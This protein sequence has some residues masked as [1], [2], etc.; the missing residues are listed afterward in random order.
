M[1]SIR[2]LLQIAVQ[3]DLLIHHMDVKS[4]SLDYEICVEPPEGF[5]G[6]NGNYVWKLKKSLYGLKQSGR[7]WNKT[8]HTYLTGQ[9]FMQSPVDP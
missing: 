3:D 9:N 2:L 5:E 7:T 4:A 1:A 6:K 8:F